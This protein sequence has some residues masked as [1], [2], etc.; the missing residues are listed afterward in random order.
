MRDRMEQTDMERIRAGRKRMGRAMRR[1]IMAMLVCLVAMVIVMF[2]GMSIFA[3][4]RERV[5][6]STAA[7]SGSRGCQH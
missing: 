5:N 6:G 4:I 1:R 2:S 7:S 3:W